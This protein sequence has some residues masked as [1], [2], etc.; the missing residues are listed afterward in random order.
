M[1]IKQGSKFVLKSKDGSK[2]LGTFDTRDQAVKR[3]KQIN[4]FKYL[5]KRKKK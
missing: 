4:F 2:T 5:S 3:E 1:I